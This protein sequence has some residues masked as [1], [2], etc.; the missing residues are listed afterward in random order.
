M[1]ELN[2]AALKAALADLAAH[3]PSDEDMRTMGWDSGQIDKACDAYANA[4]AV[5]EEKSTGIPAS[6]YG[7]ALKDLA[8]YFPSDHELVDARWEQDAVDAGCDAY[9]NAWEAL[10]TCGLVPA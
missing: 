9:A 2:P 4:K 8:K 6:V 3:F 10:K 1:N 5:L 7:E